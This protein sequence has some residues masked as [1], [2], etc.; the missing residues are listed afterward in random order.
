MKLYANYQKNQAY[1]FPIGFL[2]KP[3]KG[4]QNYNENPNRVG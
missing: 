4:K 2:K 1:I 3:E